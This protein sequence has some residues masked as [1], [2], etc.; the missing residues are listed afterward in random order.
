MEKSARVAMVPLPCR[1]SDLGS[2]EA[3]YENSA[4]DAEG[5]A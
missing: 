4:R 5:N 1:W 3:V 2:W